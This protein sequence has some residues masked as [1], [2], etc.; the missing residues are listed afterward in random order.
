MNG[1][2]I[3]V[4][5]TTCPF[6]T[7]S[8]WTSSL[9]NLVILKPW[10][11]GDF[12]P[13]NQK[14]E[15]LV[16]ELQQR[17]RS[18]FNKQIWKQLQRLDNFGV[19]RVSDRKCTESGL[20]CNSSKANHYDTVDLHFEIENGCTDARITVLKR[21]EKISQKRASLAFT[22]FYGSKDKPKG[23]A[24]GEKKD[25]IVAQRSLPKPLKS[26]F[27]HEKAFFSLIVTAYTTL[28][29]RNGWLRKLCHGVESHVGWQLF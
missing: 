12:L 3:L 7:G 20:D 11:S 23:F 25:F 28:M 26:G 29:R 6:T 15:D 21:M 16:S 5:D 18:D 4:I 22:T 19:T 24:N 1:E 13:H 14:A 10:L 2:N 8:R 17:H 27:P 9:P